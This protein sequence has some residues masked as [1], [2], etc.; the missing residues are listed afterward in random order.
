MI[1][2]DSVIQNE[3]RRA[4]TEQARTIYLYPEGTFLR[5]FDWSACNL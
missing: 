1:D 3:S 4:T 2:F 5:A